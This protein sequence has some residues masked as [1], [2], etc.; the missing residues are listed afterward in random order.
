MV[1]STSLWVAVWNNGF[2]GRVG[3]VWVQDH[4]HGESDKPAD[5]LGGDEGRH[6]DGAM[7]ANVSENILRTVTAGFA[8]DV[9]LVNQYAD[10][11]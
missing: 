1:R 4:R 2:V 9:E 8:R 3:G 11:M 6:R 5:D 10:P 7:P